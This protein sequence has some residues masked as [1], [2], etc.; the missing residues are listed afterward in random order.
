MF[1][2]TQIL[3]KKGALGTIWIASHLEKKLKRSQ[4]FET[5]IPAS[6]DSIINTEAPLALRLS[7]QLLLGVVRVYFRK[8]DYLSKDAQSAVEKLAKSST[9]GHNVDLEDEGRAA[10][11]TI[12]LGEPDFDGLGGVLGEDVFVFQGTSS[13]TLG[14][15]GAEAAGGGRRGGGLGG[16]L[17]AYSPGDS[18]AL[19]DDVSDVFG[20][21]WGIEEERF[22]APGEEM[23]RRQVGPGWLGGFSVELERLRA[24]AQ[25][26]PPGPGDMFFQAPDDDM[27]APVPDD[28]LEMP[29]PEGDMFAAGVG[30]TPA[31]TPASDLRSAG[32]GVPLP[33][34]SDIRITPQSLGLDLLPDVPG[35]SGPTFS[36]G[37]L[38]GD[39]PDV[40]GTPTK[41]S[42]QE[43][44]AGEPGATPAQQ[45]RKQ[46]QQRRRRKA[47]QLD[48]DTSGQPATTLPVKDIRALLNDRAPLLTTRGMHQR[49]Q[50]VD[51][52]PD[53]YDVVAHSEEA[54][55]S[56]LFRPATFSSLAPELLQVYTKACGS[57]GAALVSPRRTK[58]A[59]AAAAERAAEAERLHEEEQ[60]AA[61]PGTPRSPAPLQAGGEGASMAGMP[62]TSGVSPGALSFGGDAELPPLDDGAPLPLPDDGHDFIE[63]PDSQRGAGWPA[64]P[65]EEGVAGGAEAERG[66]PAARRGSLASV[67]LGALAGDGADLEGEGGRPS[68]DSEAQAAR[69]QLPQSS[70]TERSRAVL[71]EYRRRL[72][73]STG[74]KRR[75]PSQ[76]GLAATQLSLDAL[77]AGK[78]RGEACRW[79]YE[80]LVLR[81][82]DFV[83]LDQ[84]EPYGDITISAKPKMAA[85]SA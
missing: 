5:S 1:Y 20:S 73:P 70:F 69:E 24:E 21:Q 33:G 46:Q 66:G 72:L 36:V 64:G 67:E 71:A 48:V 2:S 84:R 55:S 53:R 30:A 39:L 52:P 10:Y 77:V 58:A 49:K 16:F 17:P 34:T 9:Q 8:L 28:M 50:A 62:S 79:F 31:K 14:G 51:L 29:A 27:M 45:R 54:R 7:G 80:T 85:D 15:T 18:L 60:Q 44:A 4:I 68:E 83:E 22:E 25:A 74:S 65:E 82:N 40:G 47:A 42:Q 78:S 63:P 26:P 57:A 12:T 3:S 6:V 41:A 61:V 35:G 43:E 37:T 13:G 19:V 76:G 75:H 11:G 23:D 32:D 59:A 38:P 56:L 81:S